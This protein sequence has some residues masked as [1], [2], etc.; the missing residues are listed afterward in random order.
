MGRKWI[1][2]LCCVLAVL[3]VMPAIV[4]CG[5]S[6]DETGTKTLVIGDL[7]D[8]TGPAANAMTPISWSL[9]DYS[10]YVN[11]EGLIPGVTLRVVQYDTKYDTQ[12][13]QLGYDYVKSQGASVIWTGFPGCAEALK[14][15]AE[16]DGLAII[17]ASA[18][19]P[20]VDNPGSVFC[21][22][23][24]MRGIVPA[25][26]AWVH[27]SHWQGAGTATIGMVSWNVAPN[28]DAET[29][30][31]KYCQEHPDQYTL[32]GTSLVPAGTM[33]WS[34]EVAKFKDCD[35]IWFGSGGAVAP[36]TFISEYRTAGGRATLVAGGGT[37][38]S[39][40]GA[41]SDRAGWAACDGLLE[42]INW[43]WWTYDSDQ[44][45]LAISLLQENHPSEAPGMVNRQALSGLLNAHVAVELIR[46]VV[47]NIGTDDLSGRAIYEGLQNASVELP[48]FPKMDYSQGSREGMRYSQM[49]KWSA[50]DENL[51]LVSDW[52]PNAD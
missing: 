33:T 28:P 30:L 9:Q 7:T 21:E 5:G 13:F 45:D 48:G 27:E 20:V 37:L 40:V 35:Y 25:Q 17:Q 22:A 15:R 29:A 49:W 11:R 19:V 41:V 6:K 32:V 36:A 46:A 34:A 23:G 10:D 24:L 52:I 14:T 39:Y 31:K 8:L 43:A 3:L 2:L 51:V 12:R 44:V 38:C 50:A 47:E 26:L 18:S 1:A 16:V 4:G 42:G